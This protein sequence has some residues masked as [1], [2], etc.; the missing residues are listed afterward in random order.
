MDLKQI[1]KAGDRFLQELEDAD[2][3][4]G[5]ELVK[6]FIQVLKPLDGNE[7]LKIINDRL[8]ELLILDKSETCESRKWRGKVGF[9]VELWES[10][11][12]NFIC[13]IETENDGIPYQKE[14]VNAVNNQPALPSNERPSI[15]PQQ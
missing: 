10:V 2:G 1:I 7:K 5:F 15:L 6:K 9:L 11:K 14:Q 8:K 13:Q 4:R 3:E 12:I